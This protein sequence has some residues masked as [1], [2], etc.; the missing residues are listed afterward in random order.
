[1]QSDHLE[2]WAYEFMQNKKQKPFS[3]SVLF[4]T[5][6]VGFVVSLNTQDKWYAEI[7]FNC[8][9]RLCKPNDPRPHL[10]PL[11]ETNEQLST[12]Y[13]KAS[14]RTT[15]TTSR[16]EYPSNIKVDGLERR[17]VQNTGV[18]VLGDYLDSEV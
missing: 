15:V 11:L 13:P 6:R 16:K 12:R 8:G 2:F 7:I 17:Y 3:E 4:V 18:A 9:A 5:E 1:M 10:L 14:R